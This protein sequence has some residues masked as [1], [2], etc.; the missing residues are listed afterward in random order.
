MPVY[1]SPGPGGDSGAA[2][3]S[4]SPPLRAATTAGATAGRT[5][6]RA[7]WPLAAKDMHIRCGSSENGPLKTI[8]GAPEAA[9]HNNNN[10]VALKEKKAIA[11]RVGQPQL[12]LATHDGRA[13]AT[14]GKGGARDCRGGGGGGGGGG[15]VGALSHSAR[16]KQSSRD[17]GLRPD[18]TPSASSSSSSSAGPTTLRTNGGGRKQQAA[19]QDPGAV[20]DG[21]C[22][23]GDSPPPQRQPRTSVPKPARTGPMSEPSLRR[24]VAA[25]A[26]AEGRGGKVDLRMHRFLLAS[27]SSPSCGVDSS[28]E[29]V[30]TASSPERDSH[31]AVSAV[32]PGGGGGGAH[33]SSLVAPARAADPVRSTPQQLSTGDGS[34]GTAAAAAAAATTSA[35]RSKRKL[36][37]GSAAAATTTV[38]NDDDHNDHDDQDDHDDHDGYRKH[39]TTSPQRRRSRVYAGVPAPPTSRQQQ[40]Q[41]QQQ[42]IQRSPIPIAQQQQQLQQL[43]GRTTPPIVV[44]NTT[45]TRIGQHG[46]LHGRGNNTTNNNNNKNTP[47]DGGGGGADPNVYRVVRNKAARAALIGSAC[48]TCF[49]FYQVGR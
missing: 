26:A 16:S 40:Q 20:Q 35:T 12:L 31:T 10:S 49:A 38:G 7:R 21:P 23:I 11:D 45:V 32:A 5:K 1:E 9:A 39:S 17:R 34:T 18:A 25:T 29:S 24:H 27:Q 42:P 46:H 44:V 47:H 28:P 8:T 41:R 15:G 22:G 33:Q 36:S 3:S 19:P 2:T 14:D 13:V 4:S 6:S 37:S 43:S 48:E 30:A